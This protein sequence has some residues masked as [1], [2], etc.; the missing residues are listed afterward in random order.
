MRFSSCQGLQQYSLVCQSPYLHVLIIPESKVASCLTPEVRYQ[1]VRDIPT[2]T[3]QYK[4]WDQCT[5]I[6]GVLY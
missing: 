6:W 5:K 4:M 3:L 1:E 2:Q